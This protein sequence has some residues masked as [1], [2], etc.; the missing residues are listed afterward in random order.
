MLMLVLYRREILAFFKSEVMVNADIFMG[1]IALLSGAPVGF[2]ISQ[3]WY[4]PFNLIERYVLI[5]HASPFKL[6]KKYGIKDEDLKVHYDFILHSIENKG[7]YTYL[8]RRWDLINLLGSTFVAVGIGLLLRYLK[9]CSKYAL[10]TVCDKII[11]CIMM[12][13]MFVLFV[14]VCI[15]M[16]EHNAMATYV[17]KLS[18]KRKN[19]LFGAK[20]KI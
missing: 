10:I 15:I 18:I 13:F 6:L 3:F 11:F 14:G 9:V 2:L 1:F 17:I 12:L 19:P 5:H 16:R 20:K 8:N 4:L 7:I